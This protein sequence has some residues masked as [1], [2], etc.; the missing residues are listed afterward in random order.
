MWPCPIKHPI[1]GR[2]MKQNSKNPYLNGQGGTHISDMKFDDSSQ[3]YIVQV[4]VPVKGGSKVIGALTVG[5][6]IDQLDY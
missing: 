2:V 1:I 6:D 5:I 3:A 4:S